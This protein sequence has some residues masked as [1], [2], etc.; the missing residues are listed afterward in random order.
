MF[1]GV[2]EE[3]RNNFEDAHGVLT[4]E[5]KFQ[6]I[7]YDISTRRGRV[8]VSIELCVVRTRSAHHDN[9]RFVM[10]REKRTRVT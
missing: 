1:V 6:R 7:E 4:L 5:K 8:T 2:V 9:F 10:C 3:V